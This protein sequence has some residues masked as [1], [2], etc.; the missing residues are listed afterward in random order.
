MIDIDNF[1][2]D[3]EKNEIYEICAKCYVLKNNLETEHKQ[4][5]SCHEI[6]SLL[7]YHKHDNNTYRNDCKECRNAEARSK[8]DNST[9]ECQYC[10]KE[11]SKTNITTHQKTKYCQNAQGKNVSTKRNVKATSRSKT[12]IQY[13]LNTKN[14]ITKFPSITEASKFT[15]IGR[16]NIDKCCR[17]INKS[18]GGF[19]WEIET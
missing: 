13:E 11:I 5:N 15:G 3:Y 12:V 18:A 14:I 6:K 16:T 8:R 2:T 19:Y 1:F 4:C 9:V 17:K 7:D 10:K